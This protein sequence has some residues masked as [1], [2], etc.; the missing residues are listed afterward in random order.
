MEKEDKA[1]ELFG[2]PFLERNL[3]DSNNLWSYANF[4]AKEGR[5]LD[6]ALEAA[7]TLVKLAPEVYSSWDVL[8]AVYQ[9]LKNFPEAIKAS[10]KALDLADGSM[11]DYM[12]R[13]LAQAKAA[14]KKEK[15]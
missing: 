12:Q 10:E 7:T 11:K 6:S 2:P 14:A 5:N 8:S 9:K 3:S 13:K 1:L 4:W 15:K